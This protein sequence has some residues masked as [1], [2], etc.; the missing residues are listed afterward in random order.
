MYRKIPPQDLN[1]LEFHSYFKGVGYTTFELHKLFNFDLIIDRS[2]I[3][4]WIYSNRKVEN[5]D[6]GIWRKWEERF[7]V[8]KII[9]LIVPRDLFKIRIRKNPDLYM[10]QWEYDKYIQLYEQHL[11]FSAFPIIRINRNASFATQLVTL[12]ENTSTM[13]LEISPNL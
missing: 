10:E 9:Y 6:L 1:E 12:K 13:N 3:S 8:Y 11:S 2:F 4:D 7:C 5:F